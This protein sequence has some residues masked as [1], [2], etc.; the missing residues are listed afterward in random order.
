MSTLQQTASCYCSKM[1][2]F[3]RVCMVV[4]GYIQSYVHTHTR[5]LDGEYRVTPRKQF[6][7]LQMNK[8]PWN[9]I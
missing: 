4:L 8:S 9:L 2:A 6:R 7:L 1:L 3:Q 5:T